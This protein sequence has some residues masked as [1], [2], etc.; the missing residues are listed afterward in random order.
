MKSFQLQ[1]AEMGLACCK[2]L[3]AQMLICTVQLQKQQM[4][5]LSV[6]PL[7]NA[8]HFGCETSHNSVYNT[9]KEQQWHHSLLNYDTWEIDIHPGS[10]IVEEQTVQQP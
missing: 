2:V 8:T 7:W 5:E 9:D 10:D 6:L 3:E 1:A 4:C